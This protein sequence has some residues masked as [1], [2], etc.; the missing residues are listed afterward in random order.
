MK[1]SDII[2]IEISTKFRNKP[3]PVTL[4]ET[5]LMKQP[6]ATLQCMNNKTFKESLI[7]KL[8]KHKKLHSS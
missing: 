1:I 5:V 8:L 4:I 7:Y 6:I 3:K 2:L